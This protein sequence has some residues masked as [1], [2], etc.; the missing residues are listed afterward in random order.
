M[1][2][3]SLV[4]FSCEHLLIHFGNLWHIG[5]GKIKSIS[6]LFPCVKPVKMV[7]KQNRRRVV[8]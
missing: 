8:K 1:K 3:F 6:E 7:S 2:A 5:N 4:K